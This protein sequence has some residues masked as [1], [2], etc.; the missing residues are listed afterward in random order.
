MLGLT[1]ALRGRWLW[2]MQGRWLWETWSSG[3]WH[4]NGE[5]CHAPG[6]WQRPGCGW[7][8]WVLAPRSEGRISVWVSFWSGNETPQRGV[9]LCVFIW[10][11]R[12]TR[13]FLDLPV[14]KC[15]G[16][17]YFLS[18]HFLSYWGRSCDCFL[19]ACMQRAPAV[20]LMLFHDKCRSS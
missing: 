12:S 2:E 1:A 16:Q 11:R 14:Q 19:N 7:Q 13:T 9:F 15:K 5:L 18:L 17:G 6:A 10:E 3:C 4:R 20:F 8:R